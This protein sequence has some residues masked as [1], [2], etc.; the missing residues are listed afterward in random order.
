MKCPHL[1][2]VLGAASVVCTAAFAQTVPSLPAQTLGPD[3]PL[4][5][6]EQGIELGTSVAVSGNI[7][8]V[9]APHQSG[10]TPGV[11]R[12]GLVY[13]WVGGPSGT[14]SRGDTLKGSDV[15][16]GSA[17]AME[18]DR[19]LVAGED[20]SGKAYYYVREKGHWNLR[21]VL[22]VQTDSN[23]SE[24]HTV[25]SV[26]LDDCYA[27]VGSAVPTPNSLTNGVVQVF[28]TCERHWGKLT[29]VAT[30]T[31]TDAPDEG[32]FGASL[33]LQD[34][35]LVVGEPGAE[36]GR[37]TAHV[38]ELNGRHWMPA[39]TI[40]SVDAQPGDA[41]GTSVALRDGLI[42]VGAPGA[43][44]ICCFAG[45][46]FEGAAYTFVR[47]RRG[48]TLRQAFAPAQQP[49]TLDWGGF[50]TSVAI[51]ERVLAVGAPYFPYPPMFSSYG[52]VFLLSR[53]G[54][55]YDFV[56]TLEGPFGYGNAVAI[57][58]KTLLVGAPLA[59]Y[60]APGVGVV[61]SGEADAYDMS[62]L[63]PRFRGR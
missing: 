28:D 21:Q 5:Q 16:F 43:N 35:T 4:S 14:W 32:T 42:L 50:G 59:V 57:S 23:S 39:Q 2:A 36:T 37:G 7:A 29:L 61:F 55:D 18:H 31:D 13:E 60:A 38:F 63:S 47:S 30:L 15:G 11:I 51:G 8:L 56:D 44:P 26:A 22:A 40:V 17:V 20:R 62:S 52:N 45:N 33:S 12:Q 46:L 48:W 25:V 1:S 27:A 19:A 34:R 54:Q 49:Q 6:S 58:G 10:D 9:G 53:Q 3:T 41:F 24:P